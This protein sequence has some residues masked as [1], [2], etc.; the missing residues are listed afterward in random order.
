MTSNSKAWNK[1]E[2][3]PYVSLSLMLVLVY[4]LDL[5]PNLS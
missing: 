1:F 3:K 5:A 2:K 4:S